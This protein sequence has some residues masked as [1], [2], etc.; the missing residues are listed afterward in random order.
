MQHSLIWKGV[1]YHSMENCLVEVADTGVTVQSTIVGHVDDF[2]Y[3]V[4]YNLTTS[5]RWETSSLKLTGRVGNSR[6]E[7]NLRSDGKG[8]WWLNDQPASQFAGCTDVDITLT[9]FTNS[10]PVNR[11]DWSK[12]DQVIKVVYLDILGDRITPVSQ[13]YTRISDSQ[14]KFENVPNDFEALIDVD[15]GGFVVHYPELFERAAI[16]VW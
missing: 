11:L 3:K 16:R 2:L 15:E 4:D 9:P 1:F 10:L 7:I 8:N 6:K 13:K 14:Y 5:Q 12:A